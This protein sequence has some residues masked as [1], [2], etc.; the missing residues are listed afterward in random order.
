METSDRYL[1]IHNL[2]LLQRQAGVERRVAEL[3][4][5][6]GRL[7]VDNGQPLLFD[8]RPFLAGS[9]EEDRFLELQRH[10]PEVDSRFLAFLAAYTVRMVERGYL[11]IVTRED[12]A[13][14]LGYD[15]SD[16]VAFAAKS[17]SFYREI[18][19]PRTNG[20]MRR[21]HSP[22]EP[23]RSI[24]RWVLENILNA[25][26][27]H[28]VAHGFVR[29][30]SIMSNASEHIGN[31]VL[32]AMDIADFFPSITNRRVRKGFER[33]GYPYSVALLL[34]NLC[35]RAGFLP[36]GAPTSPAL[37]N[38]ICYR[39]DRRLSGLARSRGFSYSRYA[40]D[41]AFSSNDSR[42]VLLIPFI[43]QI[44]QEDGFEVRPEKTRISRGGVRKTVTG[45]VVN[46]RPN[47][48]RTHVRMLRA[49]AHRLARQGADA[50][51]LKSRRSGSCDPER[52]LAG[53]LGFLAMINPGRC[54]ALTQVRRPNL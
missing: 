33:L 30:R 14:R 1:A 36:Q 42:L 15:L 27:P 18:C 4:T 11:P 25:Y 47:L 29:G 35:T 17:A 19:L 34:A 8:P 44:I 40:D 41:M 16:L 22:R 54:R 20:T 51:V 45:I 50:V 3:V 21:I 39:L 12:L 13:D 10:N 2:S 26:R 9:R 7:L 43:R 38:L 6:Y 28:D 53:H 37:S 5:A 52:V 48:P 49:A 31:A 24:Q 23:I 46:E 32:I